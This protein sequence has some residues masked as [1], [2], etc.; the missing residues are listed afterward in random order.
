[1]DGT[2]TELTIGRVLVLVGAILAIVGLG[3]GAIAL[4][5]TGSFLP[6]FFPLM[7]GW[8]AVAAVV[9]FAL[10]TLLGV[11][12]GFLA[13]ST[14]PSDAH[15]AGIFGIIA[16]VLPPIGLFFLVGGILLLVSP[17]AKARQGTAAPP[18]FPPR[19]A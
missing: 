19:R 13:W 17:E 6:R 10:L 14:A 11:V 3:V 16:S 9:L 4:L 18:P 15:K 5:V 2:S 12:F 7:V 1:M 8:I